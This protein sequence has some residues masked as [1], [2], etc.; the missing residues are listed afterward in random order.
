MPDINADSSSEP[1]RNEPNRNQETYDFML[2]GYAL[3]NA[4]EENSD[5]I[6]DLLHNM[7]LKKELKINYKTY[8]KKIPKTGDKFD[9][10]KSIYHRDDTW[11]PSNNFMYGQMD[12]NY[13]EKSKKKQKARR[14]GMKSNSDGTP[15][16]LW[17]LW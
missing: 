1:N 6:K 17:N 4:A 7:T 16:K 14:N 5:K 11:K 12:L 13:N 3:G 9:S 2:D 15:K 8:F 10:E